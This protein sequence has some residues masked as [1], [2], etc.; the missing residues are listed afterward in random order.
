MYC[1]YWTMIQLLTQEVVVQPTMFRL[2]KEASSRIG[3]PETTV[4]LSGSSVSPASSSINRTLQH[5]CNK[6]LS[7][8][9]TRLTDINTIN[10]NPGYSRINFTHYYTL[11]KPIAQSVMQE[12]SF[13]SLNRKQIESKKT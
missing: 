5:T 13:P 1:P 8:S 6:Q 9:K 12:Y 11:T 2:V 3:R 10:I 4:A 7:K